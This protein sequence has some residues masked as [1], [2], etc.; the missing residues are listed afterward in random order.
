MLT[1]PHG[2]ARL[3]AW[4][5]A[6]LLVETLTALL[7]TILTLKPTTNRTLNSRDSPGNINVS[8][9]NERR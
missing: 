6:W 9:N 4:Y 8:T 3:I 1:K 7:S 2:I 5:K